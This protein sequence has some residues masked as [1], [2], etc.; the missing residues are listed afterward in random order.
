MRSADM[1]PLRAQSNWGRSLPTLL[2]QPCR[3]LQFRST[4]DPPIG[5]SGFRAAQDER[6]V[7]LRNV[8]QLLRPFVG[9]AAGRSYR[10]GELHVPTTWP[11]NRQLVAGFAHW[12]PVQ[13]GT[14][15]GLPYPFGHAE[16]EKALPHAPDP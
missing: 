15:T 14:K 13:N 10:L 16:Q 3:V 11:Q 5:Q 8:W 9:R 4:K 1:T 2:P 6:G 12:V 7:P